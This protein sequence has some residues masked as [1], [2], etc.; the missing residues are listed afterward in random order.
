MDTPL[1]NASVTHALL[2]LPPTSGPLV[3]GAITTHKLIV[4]K[5]RRSTAFVILPQ[6]ALGTRGDIPVATLMCVTVKTDSLTLLHVR[7]IIV[8]LCGL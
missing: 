1:L 3:N 8:T 7:P 5:S 2:V 4:V 6:H